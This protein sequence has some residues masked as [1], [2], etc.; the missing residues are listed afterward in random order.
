MV[1][2]GWSCSNRTPKAG[3]FKHQKF[4]LTF[5]KPESPGLRD[6][7]VSGEAVR[8]QDGGWLSGSLEGTNV[9]SSCL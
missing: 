6:E 7:L 5:L 3:I 9:V 4:V 1:S 2:V 8:F